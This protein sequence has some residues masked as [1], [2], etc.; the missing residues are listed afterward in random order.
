MLFC[1]FLEKVSFVIL[2]LSSANHLDISQDIKGKYF[3]EKGKL[4]S[5][6]R[7]VKQLFTIEA[8]E[9]TANHNR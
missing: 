7:N 1:N 5:N 4:Q 2:F 9:P 8:I 6:N 3:S